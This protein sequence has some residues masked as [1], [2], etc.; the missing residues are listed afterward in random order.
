[1]LLPP[2]FAEQGL[3]NPH[4]S[5]ALRRTASQD[6]VF[7][8]WRSSVRGRPSGFGSTLARGMDRRFYERDT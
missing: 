3:P 2:T 1:M 4:A 6:K 7:G 8:D 5:G